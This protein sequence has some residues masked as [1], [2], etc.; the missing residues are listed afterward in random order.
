MKY[1]AERAARRYRLM[2]QL[3]AREKLGD[4]VKIEDDIEQIERD[5]RRRTQVTVERLE[6]A[7][8]IIHGGRASRCAAGLRE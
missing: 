2:Q 5:F 3:K 1:E 8:R 7:Q 6:D 4:A